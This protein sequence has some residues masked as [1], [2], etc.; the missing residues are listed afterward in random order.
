MSCKFMEQ[1]GIARIYHLS[2]Y[3]KYF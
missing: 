3:Y 1:F 2:R